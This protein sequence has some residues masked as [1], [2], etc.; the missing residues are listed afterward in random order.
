MGIPVVHFIFGTD[1][2]D[3][4]SN[5]LRHGP[6]RA[7]GIAED[8]TLVAAF[9]W[10]AEAA[11]AKN[12]DAAAA[13]AA[14]EAAHEG[15]LVLGGVA[16]A[17]ASHEVQVKLIASLLHPTSETTLGIHRGADAHAVVEPTPAFTHLTIKVMCR[18]VV[19]GASDVQV[20]VNPETSLRDLAKLVEAR[21]EPFRREGKRYF[22]MVE[23]IAFADETLLP[24][25]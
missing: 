8:S 17:E 12:A 3:P 20:P 6:L 10:T 4:S 23:E 22:R 19:Q 14:A 5:I 11:Y 21:L 16:A 9:S 18:G 24:Y 15:L 13:A 7:L 25:T 1:N 2:L